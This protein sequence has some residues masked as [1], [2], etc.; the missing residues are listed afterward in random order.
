MF[1]AG[2]GDA[3]PGKKPEEPA[4]DFR[5]LFFLNAV[6]VLVSELPA[7]DHDEVHEIADAEQTAREHIE[8]ART[9]LSDI[10][11]VNAEA[12]EEE[13]KQE[14]RHPVL[15]RLRAGGTAGAR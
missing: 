14:R 15:G 12:A 4:A 3:I 7:E 2:K 6:A 9:R 11:A 5:D 8:N 10:E 1:F 13:A